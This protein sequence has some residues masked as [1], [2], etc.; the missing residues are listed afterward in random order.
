MSGS[1]I[2]SVSQMGEA[3]RLA[4]AAG[5]PSLTLMENAGRAV[6]DAIATRFKPCA[7]AV[8]CGPGN[9]GG[10]GFV[11]ARHLK[12]R[13][14]DARMALL[15]A[16]ES[17]KGDAAE[18]AKRWDGEIFSLTENFVRQN[19]SSPVVTGE[20]DPA[21]R[22][23]AGSGGGKLIVVA[24]FGAG[25]SRPLE[26]VAA[27]AVRAANASGAPII[28]VDVPSGLSGDLGRP[29][30]GVCARAALTVTF[31]RKKPGHLL[32]PGRLLCGEILVT[33][34][35]TPEAVLETIRPQT[36]E[37][38]PELW[39]SV[40]PWP[41]PQ[42]HKYD[43]G[44]CVVVSGPAHSTG[45]ARLAARG[46]LRVGAGLVSIAS[47]PDAVIVNAVELTAIMVKPFNGA[48]GLAELLADK[49]F[50]AVAIGPGCGVGKGTK[51]LVKAVLA[52]G[53]S[54]VLDADALTSFASNPNELFSLLHKNCVLTPHEGEFER[55]FPSLLNKSATRL[56]ASR[57]AAATAKCVVLLKGPDTIIAAPD[58][59]AAIN[60]NAPPTLA[61]AGAG[62]V[63]TG[64]VAGLL[65]QHMPPFDAACA[66]AWLHGEAARQF[67]P[68]LIAE[69]L[70]E[71]LPKVLRAL[72]AYK[73]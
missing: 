72:Q 30:D 6:A 59:R 19:L 53:A 21:K 69:D 44:H 32:M 42:G 57:E 24:L 55:I 64:F 36:F 48:G 58:G 4:V 68:G 65:A 7:V 54:A 37:N 20:V 66:A 35:G 38:G 73:K 3:D 51:E 16:R 15:G 56:D 45:A 13:G 63:L 43:R 28:A 27:K 12:T 47:P 29:L 49:R 23:E 14:F 61:T 40:F 46:S 39:A 60:A 71:A 52:S 1:E 17:L 50:N 8:L 18:M 2:L 11:A 31:F 10:D 33:G 26:G 25:L 5:V 41:A 70:P 9:N 22:S 34:I 62:D 67:G